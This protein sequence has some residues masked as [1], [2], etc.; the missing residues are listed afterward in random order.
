[1]IN[2]VFNGINSNNRYLQNKNRVAFSGVPTPPAYFAT[3]EK[4]VSSNSK[5]AGNFVWQ[6]GKFVLQPAREF[7]TRIFNSEPIQKLA[8]NPS[9]G[10]IWANIILIGVNMTVRPI[11]VL[12]EKDKTKNKPSENKQENKEVQQDDK[13]KKAA[14][15]YT[16]ARLFLQEGFGL[17]AMA[18]FLLYPIPKHIG[19]N[20]GKRLAGAKNAD[21]FKQNTVKHVKE[22]LKKDKNFKVPDLIEKSF[23]MGEAITTIVALSF[24]GPM[25]NNM[26]VNPFLKMIGVDISS[27]KKENKEKTK[28]A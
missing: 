23:R 27:N 14:K 22:M 7:L 13:S 20:L 19:W 25:L 4:F 21:L 26:T 9:F 6:H 11:C 12:L 8:G 3:V 17:A 28:E 15:I 5:Q 24:L 18:A 10:A 2:N 16:A 1:M